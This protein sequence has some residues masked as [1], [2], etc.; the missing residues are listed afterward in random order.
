MVAGCEIWRR[1]KNRRRRER[2]DDDLDWA[3]KKLGLPLLHPELDDDDGNNDG[4]EEGRSGGGNG[5]LTTAMGGIRPSYNSSSPN[6]SVVKVRID[7]SYNVRVLWEGKFKELLVSAGVSLGPLSGAGMLDPRGVSA[8]GGM[9]MGMG[10]GG[11]GR[12]DS[13]GY[14]LTGIGMSILYS[15]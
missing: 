9:G 13:R 3:R 5:A 8:N 14:G 4:H 1:N 15:S 11:V 6:D 2:E 7:Q 10:M 12:H